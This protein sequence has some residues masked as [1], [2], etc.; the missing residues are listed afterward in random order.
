MNAIS[1]IEF[2]VY[3]NEELVGVNMTRYALT[4]KKEKNGII[5]VYYSGVFLIYLISIV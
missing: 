1:I 4:L 3:V 5:F 2:E